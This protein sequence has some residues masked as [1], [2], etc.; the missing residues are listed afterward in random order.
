MTAGP[1]ATPAA[2]TDGPPAVE[3]AG[4]SRRFR[5]G[6][7]AG[8][9]D[10]A[11]RPSEVVALVG[12]NGSG[13]STLLRCL[14][15]LTRPTAGTVRWW[16]DPRVARARPR[17]GVAFEVTA[18]VEEASGIQNLAFFAARQGRRRERPGPG[19]APAVDRGRLEAIL[20]DEDLLG[21]ADDPVATYSFGM[22]RRLLLA[23]ALCHEPDLLLLDEP[24]VGLDVGATQRLSATL[25]HAAEAGAAVCLASNDTAFVERTADRV[26]FLDGGRLVRDAA[27]ATLLAELGPL[28]EMRLRCAGPPPLERLRRLPGVVTIARTS[29]G[30]VLTAHRRDGLVAD[31]VHALGDADRVLQDLQIRDPDLADCFLAL[32]G[33]PLEA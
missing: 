20:D 26:G 25:R 9:V 27:V 17:L 6:R 11:V 13:K 10:L 12:P 21:V 2:E 5:N 7:G 19:P 14:A 32:V 24:T 22:R 23:E 15:T 4:L 31:V 8:P 3:A 29:D 28:R 16:G 30:V 18:H 33:R 1:G